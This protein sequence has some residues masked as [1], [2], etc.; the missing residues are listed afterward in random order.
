MIDLETFRADAQAWLAT[1]VPEFG[2]DARRGISDEADLALGRRYMAA[3][4][5]AGFGG[6]HMA[7]EFGGRGL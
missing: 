6:I 5:E 1:M 7:E 3:K 4:Y 2:R